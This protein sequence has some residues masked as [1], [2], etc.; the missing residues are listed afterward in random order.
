MF[1]RDTTP[2]SPLTYYRTGFLLSYLDKYFRYLKTPDEVRPYH[3][4]NTLADIRT[5]LKLLT[6]CGVAD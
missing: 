6:L 5:Q 2:D 3:L 1:E 4:Q